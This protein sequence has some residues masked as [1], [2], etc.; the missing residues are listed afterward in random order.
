MM[1]SEDDMIKTTALA[2]AIGES[3][4]SNNDSTDI[5]I[6][7][8]AITVARVFDGIEMM[9]GAEYVD[10]ATGMFQETCDSAVAA[11]RSVNKMAIN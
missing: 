5:A 4:A 8:L 10:K 7:A 6:W 11:Y 3:L 2:E 1:A 9:S